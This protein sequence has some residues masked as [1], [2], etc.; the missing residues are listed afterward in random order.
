VFGL[1]CFAYSET[2]NWRMKSVQTFFPSKKWWYDALNK[3][4]SSSNVQTFFQRFPDFLFP[5]YALR[6]WGLNLFRFS[7][8]NRKKYKTASP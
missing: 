7:F 5:L 4:L 1:L 2:G 8:S 3:T 6:N